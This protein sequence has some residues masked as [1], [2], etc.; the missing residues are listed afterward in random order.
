MSEFTFVD[1]VPE[2]QRGRNQLYAD[3][4]AAL[5]ENS[6]KWA[7]WPREFKNKATASAAA[8]NVQ[9][10]ILA[11]FPPGEFEARMVD[12]VVYTRHIGGA[13]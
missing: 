11:N 9:R 4:A 13:S 6:G 8:A 7:V 12:G 3:F 1:E 2:A 5:R 10:G